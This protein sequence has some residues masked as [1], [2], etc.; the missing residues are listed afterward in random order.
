MDIRKRL[1]LIIGLI[2]GV[3]LLLVLV[4]VLRPA[5]E[6]QA[7]ELEGAT[8]VEEVQ[9]QLEQEANEQVFTP[10]PVVIEPEAPEASERRYVGQLAGIFVERFGTYSNQNDNRHIAD[11]V[12]MATTRMQPWLEKQAQD[13]GAQYAGMTTNVISRSV[14][15]Y[16]EDTRA[17]VRL[18]VQQIVQR[19]GEE[20][21]SYRTARVEL[22]KGTGGWLVD[23]MYWED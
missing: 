10:P 19:A 5:E 17:T 6:E 15:A 22:V 8:T 23:G 18:G 21:D 9:Q 14:D 20:T 7:P 4:V 1:L 12:E 16:T 2:L 3:I 11:V 13:Q